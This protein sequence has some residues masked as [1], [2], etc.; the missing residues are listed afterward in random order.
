MG[1]V[2]TRVQL[3]NW[4]DEIDVKRGLLT[5]EQVRSIEVD[6]IV[7]TCAS[8]LVLPKWIAEQ[9]GIEARRMATVRYADGRLARKPVAIG[10][11]IAIA[12]R[13]TVADAVIEEDG[14][15]VLVGYTV[16]QLLDLIVDPMN[17]IIS[18]RPESPDMPM[19]DLL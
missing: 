19:I 3:W 18:P 14:N 9:L 4:A 5:P 1:K 12:G 6:A 17:E 10:V 13:D 16:L 15:E 11:R 2:V 8:H 7:D